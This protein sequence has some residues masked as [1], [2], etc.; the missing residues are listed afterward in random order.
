MNKPIKIK[1][2][3]DI[4]E[5][6]LNYIKVWK[7]SY[8]GYHDYMEKGLTVMVKPFLYL[9]YITIQIKISIKHD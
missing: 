1:G 9:Y 4:I 2:L 5:F 7:D 8:W 3:G 6:I